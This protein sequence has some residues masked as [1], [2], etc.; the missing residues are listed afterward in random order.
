MHIIASLRFI[1][2]QVRK[3]R[4]EN[5]EEKETTNIEKKNKV[6]DISFAYTRYSKDRH[7]LMVGIR[8]ICS[9][10]ILETD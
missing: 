4:Y 10:K 2:C 9:Q 3:K 7:L 1:Y 6:R 8:F 5:E